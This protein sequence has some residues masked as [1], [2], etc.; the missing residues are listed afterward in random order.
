[1][2]GLCAPVLADTSASRC[3][4]WCGRYCQVGLR[5]GGPAGSLTLLRPTS[6]FY[7]QGVKANVL[8]LDNK[9]GQEKPWTK[10][11]WVYDRRT[12]VHFTLKSKSLNRSDLNDFGQGYHPGNRHLRRATWNEKT[13]EG[14]W[15]AF[16]YE[17]LIKRDKTNLD[18]VWLKDKSLEGSED[19]LEPAILAQ[20]IAHDLQTAVEL[21][22][23][24]AS[25]LAN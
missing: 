5:D 22:G 21:F 23:A 25:E 13:P 19:L 16:D 14:R 2:L 11:L 15:R 10:K 8:F 3:P 1:M 17:E 18:I 4:A 24:I 9:T 12:N 6:I 20:E 7:A